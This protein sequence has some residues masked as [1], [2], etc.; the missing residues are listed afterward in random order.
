MVRNDAPRFGTAG[1][2]DSFRAGG[3]KT[4]EDIAAFTASFGL[5]AFE[6]Q[7]GRGVRI[8]DA[9]AAALGAA[10]AG[11]GI[12]LSV[13]AP[14]YIS[15][16][17]LEED[18]RLHSIDYL[19]QSCAAVRA[20]GGRRVIFHPGSCGRQSREN[21]LDKALDTMRRAVAAVDAAGFGDCILCPETMGKVNQLGTL[22]EVLALCAVDP[23]ITPCIDFGHLYARSQGSEF[24][25]AAA[26]GD[27]A[28]L[29]DRLDRALGDERART[30]HVHFSR[31]A[32]TQGGEKCHLTFANTAYGPPHQPLMALF[33]ARGL[34]PTVICESAGTQAEDAAALAAAWAAAP[35]A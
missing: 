16:S 9:R 31:I 17:S 18:K 32:Y 22:E 19:L 14:Y 24:A 33:K 10:C 8:Q 11:R 7:C 5:T 4:P 12:A 34:C 25:G 13:H 3:G 23:R 35:Q 30:F 21:A 15:M 29:L 20:M 2:S 6:Y 27:Y 28:A 26:A 1:L